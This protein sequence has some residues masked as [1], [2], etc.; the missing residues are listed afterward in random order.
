MKIAA[1]TEDG[2]TISKHFGR[3]AHFAVVTVEEGRIVGQE[4][5]DNPGRHGLDTGP[6]EPRR[7]QP[8]TQPDC[9]G[10]GTKAAADHQRIAA[11][12]ADCEAVLAGGMSWAS[13]ECLASNGIKPVITDIEAIEQAVAAYADGTIVDHAEWLH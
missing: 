1:V 2:K 6:H 4:L 11:A 12:I 9:H 7:G 13:R 5:R 3:A 8:G 10:Y